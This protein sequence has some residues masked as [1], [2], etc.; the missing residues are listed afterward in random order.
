MKLENRRISTITLMLLL[1]TSI[2]IAYAVPQQSHKF[3]GEVTIGVAEAP[4]GTI[5]EAKIGGT[6]Y[7]DTTT[8]GGRYG[9]DPIFKV[10][11]DDPGTTEIEGGVTGNTVEFY[12]GGVLA[13]TYLFEIGGSTPLNLSIS[14]D[15]PVA[16]A[17][18][19]RARVL[20][21]VLTREAA[22]NM[23]RPDKAL[24]PTFF[25]T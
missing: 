8:T 17:N 22:E 12:V 4:D 21:H 10:P 5:I 9:W 18:G 25:N 1:F 2:G 20:C 7:V 15:P 19:P 24:S 3:W 13:T 23:G 6:T 16:D 11:A 14:N